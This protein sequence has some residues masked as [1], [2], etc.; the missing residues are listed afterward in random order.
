VIGVDVRG[1]AARWSSPPAPSAA[2]RRRRE[3][4]PIDRDQLNRF[5]RHLRASSNAT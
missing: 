2:G 1:S 4:P 5:E 3:L